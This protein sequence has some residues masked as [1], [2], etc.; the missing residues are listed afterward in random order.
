MCTTALMPAS[1]QVL[2]PPPAA[3]RAQ[4]FLT[5]ITGW[6]TTVGLV[7]VLTAV[8]VI[9]AADTGA[10]FVGKSLGRTKLTDISPKKTVEGAAGGLA[11][12]V[13]TALGSWALFGWPG[14]PLAAVVLGVS[15]TA[16]W[17]MGGAERGRGPAWKAVK[18]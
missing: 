14:S 16:G 12:A 9:I 4:A 13:A 10:Y 2:S 15:A 18:V 3:P 6:P 17:G 11:A 7:A 8:A 1:P 5:G